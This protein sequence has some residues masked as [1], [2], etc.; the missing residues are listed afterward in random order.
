MAHLKDSDVEQ[1]PTGDVEKPAKGDVIDERWFVEEYFPPR[2]D[3]GSGLALGET[4]NRN[5]AEVF[6]TESDAN[7][8][9][10]KHSPDYEGGKFRK[11]HEVLIQVKTQQWVA[12]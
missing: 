1:L 9:I 3:S 8:W 7:S 11:V 5:Y 4:W 2:I 10:A 12:A 6:A